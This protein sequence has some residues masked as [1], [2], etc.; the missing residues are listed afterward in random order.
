MSATLD[1]AKEKR[2]LGCAGGPGGKSLSAPRLTAEH[3]TALSPKPCFLVAHCTTRNPQCTRSLVRA[4]P[5]Q[6]R[7]SHSVAT[8]GRRPHRHGQPQGRGPMPES[9]GTMRNTPLTRAERHVGGSYAITHLNRTFSQVALTSALQI[10]QLPRLEPS[11]PPT[12]SPTARSPPNS[13][14]CHC[15]LAF[16]L[17]STALSNFHGSGID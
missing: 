16:P 7:R 10:Q 1:A 14:T 5:R 9:S 17:K 8:A 6:C 2:G 4:A 12:P 15:A 13:S 3:V 11:N